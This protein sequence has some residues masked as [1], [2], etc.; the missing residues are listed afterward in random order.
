MLSL[1]PPL[2]AIVL[3]IA[4]RRVVPSLLFGVVVGAALVHGPDPR[5]IVY[6]L[7][8]T[9]LWASL[10]DMGHVQVFCFTALIGAMIGVVQKSGGM[11]GVV[12]AMA[13]LA[14]T[15]RSG[16]IMTWALGLI[17]FIDDY[18]NSLLLGHTMRPFADRLKISREKLAYIVDS[19][20]AP[21][22]GLALVSTWV[23]GEI[24]NIETG[25]AEVTFAE[26]EVEAFAL[27]VKTIP[28]RFYVLWA[29]ALVP[30]N[31]L[32]KRDFGPMLAAEKKAIHGSARDESDPGEDPDE[33]SG[34]DS[35]ED[36]D[37]DNQAATEPAATD[38]WWNAVAP[39]AIT[40]VVAVGLLYWTGASSL[41]A[42][43]KSVGSLWDLREA[44]RIFG[45]GDSYA[46]LLYSSIAG[47]LFA[48]MLIAP[49]RIVSLRQLNAAA[50]E[51]A[52]LVV[53]AMLILWLAWT[54]SDL[55]GDDHLRTGQYLG[56]VLERGVAPPWMPTL[57]FL[58]AF[59]VAFAT[60]TSWGT[61]SMLMPLA[62]Q[63][64]V[65]LLGGDGVASVNDPIL[66]ASVGGVLAGAIFGDHCSPI[67]DTTVLSS[68]A[69]GCHH[70]AHVWT[71][72]PYAM[73]VGVVAVV[74]GTI[75]VG[76]GA[77][78]YVML[79]LGLAALVALLLILGKDPE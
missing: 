66:I 23:A 39:I 37:E 21:V 20:A 25:L 34:K 55:T 5:T 22:S 41:R 50:I 51:G 3:A 43:G 32:L 57:V 12:A 36:P 2:A 64:T 59:G 60:G 76:F 29:L 71:Q 19:T 75:P 1:L 31:A 78:V 11:R 45:A 61:M 26:G 72:L 47:L 69:S 40:V 17:V 53:P 65:T 62:I 42:D 14:K 18:A 48:C 58:L 8:V 16:Q 38:R 68:Q 77:P 70:I 6:E 79:P 49:Q 35:D 9:H 4:T 54:L 74:F 44:G 7:G 52:K 10:S 63:T 24:A 33:D 28:Y 67:S 46:A 15:R 73:L 27:F 30:L 56:G 13:P